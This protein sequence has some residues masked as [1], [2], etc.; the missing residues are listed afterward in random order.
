LNRERVKA[1]NVAGIRHSRA[2]LIG[3]RVERFLDAV[4]ERVKRGE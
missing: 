4:F 1:L 2:P 3:A